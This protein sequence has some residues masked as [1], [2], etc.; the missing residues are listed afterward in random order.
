MKHIEPFSSLMELAHGLE[1]GRFL[2]VEVASLYLERIR[3]SQSTLRAFVAVDEE[4]AIAAAAASDRR[5]AFGKTLSALDGVP[6]AIKDMFAMAGQAW[7][8]GAPAWSDRLSEVD[9]A[10]VAKLKN[11]GAC[12]LGRTNM[13]ELAFGAWGLNSALGTPWN[14]WDLSIH[15]IPGGSSSGSAVAVA[16]GLA[17]VAIGSDTGGSVRGP[18]ALSGV[19]GFKASHGL[20]DLT[21]ALPLSERLDSVGVLSRTVN[22]AA[23]V[24]SVLGAPLH[25]VFTK[26]PVR[27]GESP[28]RP[29]SGTRIIVLDEA[30]FG[31]AVDDEIMVAF[32][33]AAQI[34]ERLGARLERQAWPFHIHQ[35]IEACG[36]MMAADGWRLHHAA[37]AATPGLPASEAVAKRL[38]AGQNIDIERYRQLLAFQVVIT[39]SWNHWLGS[40][41][42]VLMPTVPIL[43]CPLEE[44]DESS[45]ALGL[46]NRLGNFVGG[47]SVSLPAGVSRSGLPMGVQLLARGKDDADLASIGAAFQFGSDFHRRAPDLAGIGL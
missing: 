22:D 21:G 30:S 36:A 3:R 26:T 46:F 20:I 23:L 43:A 24:L 10:V 7:G 14:P 11:A 34:L 1:S 5:R 37:L 42:A 13:V 19:T 2:A 15:R 41:R 27:F 9:S 28:G 40:A 35:V 4:A 44:V 31:G 32:Q 38:S 29:L 8:C 17:P 33:N 12:L 16:A 25:D 18:A 6:I 39:Q 47:C 45:L